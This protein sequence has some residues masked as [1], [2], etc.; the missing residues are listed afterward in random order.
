VEFPAEVKG[1]GIQ[2]SSYC[3]HENQRQEQAHA[4]PPK[5]SEAA[6]ALL[7]PS[8]H[9]RRFLWRGHENRKRRTP[10]YIT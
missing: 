1:P 7:L 9:F 2:K 10:S 5:A 4:Y 6:W 8:R 3:G